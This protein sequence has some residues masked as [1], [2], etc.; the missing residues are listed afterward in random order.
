[1]TNITY[2]LTNDSGYCIYN[3]AIWDDYQTY[4]SGAS[5]SAGDI[6]AFSFAG[7]PG[8][9][10]HV[11]GYSCDYYFIQVFSENFYGT[12]GTHTVEFTGEGDDNVQSS[13]SG[14]PLCDGSNS[15]V[16]LTH[17]YYFADG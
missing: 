3:L 14:Y 10:Y 9:L 4:V 12:L 5:I 16:W 17:N 2:W 8:R 13:E 6:G 11:F 7:V 15:G 1:S